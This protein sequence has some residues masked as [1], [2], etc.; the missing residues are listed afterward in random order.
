MAKQSAGLLLYRFNDN[1]VEVLLAH[2]GGP[3]HAKKDGGHWTIPKGEY[4][5]GEDAFQT[6]YR[7]FQE[8][9]GS[10]PPKGKPSELGSIKQKNNK[11]VTAWAI[12]GDFDAK[13]I[14]SNTFRLEWPPRS[15]KIQEFPEIDRAGWFNLEAAAR[16][17][18]PMQ[19]E[20][21]DRLAEKL[22][23]RPTTKAEQSSLL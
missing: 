12:E 23:Y 11:A 8:E 7:E 13:N 4:E 15:G 9:F 10:P 5:E 6:A 3:F 1:Q 14:K 18:I 2:M 16:K 20:F 19:A 22:N 17:L 21:L